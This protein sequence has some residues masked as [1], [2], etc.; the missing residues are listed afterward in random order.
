[1]WYLINICKRE[2]NVRGGKGR[3]K[4]RRERDGEKDSNEVFFR[5]FRN[6]KGSRDYLG[7][8]IKFY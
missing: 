8:V 1:M 3:D 7:D 5:I 4:E 2:R 6:V